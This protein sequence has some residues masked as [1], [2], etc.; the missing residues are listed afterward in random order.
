MADKLFLFVVVVVDRRITGCFFVFEVGLVAGNKAVMSREV[1]E[2]NVIVDTL[3]IFET[4]KMN[5][6]WVVF[7]GLVDDVAILGDSA[8]K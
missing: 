1:V 8:V 4:F 6:S 3:P 7:L 2:E 5:L